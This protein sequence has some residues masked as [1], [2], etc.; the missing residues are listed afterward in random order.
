ML[1][2]EIVTYIADIIYIPD[3]CRQ[4]FYIV[5]IAPLRAAVVHMMA[6]NRIGSFFIL[7]F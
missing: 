7:T 3:I 1:P 6:K 5:N 2:G 4:F